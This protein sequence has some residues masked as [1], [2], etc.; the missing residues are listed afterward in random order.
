M[1]ATSAAFSLGDLFDDVGDAIDDLLDD[2]GDAGEALVDALDDAIDV[3][4]DRLDDLFDE[5]DDLIADFIDQGQEDAPEPGVS[6]ELFWGDDG[7]DRVRGLPGEGYGP[8]T[9][10][11]LFG[12][13]G[14]DI[15]S[16]SDEADLLIGGTGRD[17]I[18]G[19]FGGDF[20]FGNAGGD[21]IGG[22]AGDDF[23]FGG[24]GNDDLFG[25]DDRD[26]IFGGGGADRIRGDAGRDV[27]HGN[28]GADRFEY[29][30]MS[31]LT[32]GALRD[33]IVDFTKGRDKI[34]LGNIGD[35]NTYI[36]DAPFSGT[37][38]EIRCNNGI[39]AINEDDDTTADFQVRLI[40]IDTL[41]VDDLIFN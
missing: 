9:G 34:V 6:R 39:L 4:G 23:I 25:G 18:V 41:A 30:E 33:V 16:G 12:E 21:G 37:P 38:G 27:M 32:P 28:A 11:V 15:L 20:L 24:S 10:A 40:G 3:A 31:E 14:D 22:G 5:L 1:P 35:V 19:I 13:D 26:T 8:I 2:F 7:N 36:G 17:V 29:T